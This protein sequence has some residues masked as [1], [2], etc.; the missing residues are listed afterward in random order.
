MAARSSIP[1]GAGRLLPVAVLLALATACAN[2]PVRPNDPDAPEVSTPPVM[3]TT[4]PAVSDPA[5]PGESGLPDVEPWP[6]YRWSDAPRGPRESD[7]LDDEFR[8]SRAPGNRRPTVV[9][10]DPSPSPDGVE[11]DHDPRT[12]PTGIDCGT[13]ETRGRTLLVRASGAPIDCTRARQIVAAH[14]DALP[15][16]AQ[17]GAPGTAGV[18][19]GEW[20]CV[21]PTS[22]QTETLDAAFADRSAAGPSGQRPPVP[23]P[24]TA[25]P[26]AAEWDAPAEPG[27]VRSRIASRRD[28]RDVGLCTH[29][30]GVRVVVATEQD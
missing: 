21:V 13:V 10:A 11:V 9:P 7:D 24:R 15:A 14:Q 3:E 18:R 30:D 23:S 26:P 27:E 22:D 2:E 19:I 6:T 29:A 16:G 1:S 4:G 25:P 8:P 17:P 28:G 12:T 20:H 5:R